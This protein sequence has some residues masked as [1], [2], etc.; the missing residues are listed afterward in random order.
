[1][2]NKSTRRKFS[3]KILMIMKNSKVLTEISMQLTN[4]KKRLQPKRKGYAI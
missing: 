2:T 1:M 3:V 4:D